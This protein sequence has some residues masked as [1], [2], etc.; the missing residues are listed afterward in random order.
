MFRLL[1]ANTAISAVAYLTISAV[2]LLLVPVLLG[3]YGL[4]AFGL[5]TLARLFLPTS[6][7]AFVDFGFSE[8]A[9][10]A[11]AQARADN[12]WDRAGADVT[13]LAVAAI[14]TGLAGGA[15]LFVAGGR[16]AAAFDV[17]P[18]HHAAFVTVLH[19]TGAALPLLFVSLVLE[20]VVKGFENYAM[21]R[22]CEVAGSFGFAGAALIAVRLDQG[23]E[24]V[25]YALIG[26]QLL[27]AALVAMSAVRSGTR[28]GLGLRGWSARSISDT[29]RRCRLVASAKVLGT[30][31]TQA[32][33]L[34]IGA[35]VGPAAVG[36][37]DVLSRLPRFAKAVLGLVNATLLPVA[38]RLETARDTANM[39]R[40]GETGILIIL[41]VTVPPIVAG[42]AF[43]PAIL[44]VWIGPVLRHFWP[45]LTA[46]FLIPL[47]TVLVSF[48][49]NTLFARP[50]AFYRMNIYTLIQLVAQ[51]AVGLALTGWLHER[52][53]ILGQVVATALLFPWQ[54]R[55]IVREQ[56]LGRIVYFWLFRSTL[57]GAAVGTAGALVAPLVRTPFELGIAGLAWMAGHFVLGCFFVASRGQREAALA[58]ARR[59]WERK[60]QGL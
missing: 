14:A 22:A 11:V 31:Q 39:R 26:A 54:M 27:R 18:E 16:I 50:A 21:Q 33:P 45:W 19:I 20:G 41:L 55:L 44:G 52:A 1:A 53:Y 60:A 17:P 7:L 24:V 5:I 35:L 46:M 3:S 25:C 15:L 40:L 34:L 12:A 32:A 8:V 59:L 47:L 58:I 37:Y 10:Q 48:G 30:I 2:G 28:A 42:M 9:T 29:F 36:V 43:A 38:I 13:L 51:F 23:F 57:L 56:D 49:G 6:G 4:V